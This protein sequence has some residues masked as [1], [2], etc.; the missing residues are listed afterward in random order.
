MKQLV[1]G[2][3]IA[4]TYWLLSDKTSAISQIGEALGARRSLS[5]A[6]GVILTQ[7]QLKRALPSRP[8]T[9]QQNALGR[10]WQYNLPQASLVILQSHDIAMDTSHAPPIAVI[11]IACRFPGE[12]N[13]PL[14]FWELLKSGRSVLQIP[15]SMQTSEI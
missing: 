15:S 4:C 14:G 1:G 2:C 13:S 5:R 11:G 8:P 9:L 10:T 6:Y 12:A 3:I 7:Y